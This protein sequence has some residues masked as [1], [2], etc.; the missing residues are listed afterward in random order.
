MSA[1]DGGLNFPEGRH[2]DEM[3]IALRN[4]ATFRLIYP[5][6]VW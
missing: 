2:E 3:R 1:G 6:E 5:S 4:L